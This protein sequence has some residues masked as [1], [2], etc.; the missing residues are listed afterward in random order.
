MRRAVERGVERGGGTVYVMTNGRKSK[1][2]RKRIEGTVRLQEPSNK[3]ERQTT[4]PQVDV[5][6]GRVGKEWAGRR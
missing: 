2:E 1:K 5:N 4:E 6:C 3:E